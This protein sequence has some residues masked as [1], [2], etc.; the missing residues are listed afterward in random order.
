[1]A[2]RRV[3][4]STLGSFA[5]ASSTVSDRRRAAPLAG[6]QRDRTARRT[7]PSPR[8]S[9]RPGSL[10]RTGCAACPPRADALGDVAV[11]RSACPSTMRRSSAFAA[12]Q[13]LF[14]VTVTSSSFRC[15]RRPRRS[16]DGALEDERVGHVDDAPVSGRPSPVADLHHDEAERGTSTTSPCAGRSR[17]GPYAEGVRTMR[18][19]H[20]AKV[21]DG[22]LE[23]DR[24]AV[25]NSPG[26]WPGPLRRGPRCR[27]RRG[28]ERR[29]GSSEGL[30]RDWKRSDVCSRPPTR[31]RPRRAN[32]RYASTKAAVVSSPSVTCGSMPSQVWTVLSNRSNGP[33]PSEDTR[34]HAFSSTSRAMRRIWISSVPPPIWR[35]F[36][37]RASIS[38][39]PSCM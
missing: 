9:T 5:K 1:M 36:A 29:R 2:G 8:R 25:E 35:S 13:S 22:V 3:G 38:T 16:R 14:I 17:C 39:M 7:P 21:G 24:E 26:T 11:R 32:P 31:R 33:I 10:C 19:S 27:G 30:R 18:K 12:F 34:L 28:G 15:S 6:L 37:S 23:G 4:E 20:P